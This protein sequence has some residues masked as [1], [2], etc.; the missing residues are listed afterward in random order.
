LTAL[1]IK[2]PA[3]VLDHAGR[4]GRRPLADRDDDRHGFVTHQRPGLPCRQ[5]IELA[6]HHS[7]RP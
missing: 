7:A 6:P 5:D 2:L 4:L 1:T 3:P